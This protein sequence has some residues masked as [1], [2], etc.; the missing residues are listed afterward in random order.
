MVYKINKFM[1]VNLLTPIKSAFILYKFML[2]LTA[3]ACFQKLSKWL[4]QRGN[5]FRVRITYRD[6]NALVR[7]VS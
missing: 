7:V 4:L 5:G 2:Y 1:F 3:I 6:T